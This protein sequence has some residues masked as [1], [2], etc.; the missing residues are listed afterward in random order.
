M[1]RPEQQSRFAADDARFEAAI[2][3]AREAEERSRRWI[4][5]RE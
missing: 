1:I 2:A 3:K 4:E 5:G